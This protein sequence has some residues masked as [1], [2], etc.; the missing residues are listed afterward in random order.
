MV[1]Q[2]T[3]R[4]D[5]R[6]TITYDHLLAEDAAVGCSKGNMFHLE[7]LLGHQGKIF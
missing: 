7:N 1:F 6:F 3:T 5:S 2:P 4:T